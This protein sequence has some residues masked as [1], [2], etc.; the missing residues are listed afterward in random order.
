LWEVRTHKPGPPARGSLLRVQDQM[1]KK[2]QSRFATHLLRVGAYVAAAFW[3]AFAYAGGVLASRPETE[4]HSHLVG[5]TI[6]FVAVVVMIATVDHWV[7]YLQVILGGAIFGC[8]LAL[9][10]GHL[11]NN[12]PFPRSIAAGLTALFVG[13]SLI[14][15]TLARRRLTMFDRAALIAFVAAFVV[16]IVQDTPTAGLIGL[17]I[18]FCFLSVAWLRGRYSST[19]RASPDP[20]RDS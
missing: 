17:G 2:P 9:G 19:G 13:C 8:L 15:R 20:A 16:G 14:S 6:L 18:G 11:L 1:S 10:S 4:T 12:Q 3:L 7:R 5:W